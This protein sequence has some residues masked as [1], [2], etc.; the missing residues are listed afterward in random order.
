MDNDCNKMSIEAPDIPGCDYELYSRWLRK[1]HGM[2]WWLKK[3]T[4]NVLTKVEGNRD[5]ESEN[6]WVAK[7][8]GYPLLIDFEKIWLWDHDG[9]LKVDIRMEYPD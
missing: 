1:S 8:K 9:G 3:E 7:A 5:A 2:P 6:Y 4:L